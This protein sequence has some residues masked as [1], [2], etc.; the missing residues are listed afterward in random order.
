YDN[1]TGLQAVKRVD[2]QNHQGAFLWN[3]GSRPFSNRL[4]NILKDVVTI[5]N[6]PYVGVSSAAGWN[7]AFVRGRVDNPGTPN[8]P[9]IEGDVFVVLPGFPGAGTY[10]PSYYE[11]LS[12]TDANNLLLRS[13]APMADP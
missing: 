1:I 9:V 10:T 12:V 2:D 4:L 7:V 6:D 11:I 3:L 13:A 5:N 8:M